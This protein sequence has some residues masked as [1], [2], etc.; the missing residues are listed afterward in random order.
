MG[1]LDYVESSVTIVT[2]LLVHS[3]LLFG[4]GHCRQGCSAAKRKKEGP[5]RCAHSDILDKFAF[6]VKTPHCSFK[7]VQWVFIMYGW[8]NPK[9]LSCQPPGAKKFC[10][11]MSRSPVLLMRI[12]CSPSCTLSMKRSTSVGS[13]I[14]RVWLVCTAGMEVTPEHLAKNTGLIA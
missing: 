10:N 5:G 8:Y 4:E 7:A 11:F 3:R 1:H 9:L 14:P 13:L 12:I 6:F 2:N